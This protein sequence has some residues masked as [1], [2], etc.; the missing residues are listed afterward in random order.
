MAKKKTLIVSNHESPTPLSLATELRIIEMQI[1]SL[2]VMKTL[3]RDDLLQQLKAQGVRSVKLD[4]GDQYIRT[5]RA[6]LVIKDAT[7]ARAFAE[8][9][10]AMKIDTAKVLKIIKPMLDVPNFF[11][12]G[13]TE[14]LRILRRGQSTEY[15]VEVDGVINKINIKYNGHFKSK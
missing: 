12:I 15:N 5:E 8:E 1:E 10:F 7:K 11:G 4:N 6:A 3:I 14:Y 2:E 9:R 13:H